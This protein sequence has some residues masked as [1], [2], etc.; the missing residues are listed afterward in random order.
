MVGSKLFTAG[1][2]RRPAAAAS[3]APPPCRGLT[4]RGLMCSLVRLLHLLLLYPQKYDHLMEANERSGSFYLQSKV[5]RAKERLEQEVQEAGGGVPPGA[6]AG[7]AQQ[8][9]QQQQGGQGQ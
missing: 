3:R 2:G 6:A 4:C 5:F 9:Q 7:D 8:Q 1:A